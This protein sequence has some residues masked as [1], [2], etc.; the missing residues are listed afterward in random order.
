MRCL[1]F[2][3]ALPFSSKTSRVPPSGLP[4]DWSKLRI[5]LKTYLDLWFG[6]KTMRLLTVHTSSAGRPAPKGAFTPV[7]SKKNW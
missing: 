5:R 6:L 3:S 7:G 2:S 1:R 4:V